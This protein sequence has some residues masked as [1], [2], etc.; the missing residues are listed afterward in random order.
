MDEEESPPQTYMSF[1][2]L[3]RTPKTWGVPYMAGLFILCVSLLPALVLGTFVHGLGW[4]FAL[5]GAPLLFY[6][7]S[8]CETDDRAL[9]V[10]Q[11]EIKWSILKKM[12]GNAKFYGGLMTVAPTSYGRKIF[13]VRR[14]MEALKR[15][16]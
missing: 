12:G 14:G 13:N 15:P 11:L 10:L 6:V 7:K 9:R 2:G 3:G 8:Q 4:A 16:C 5:I 1:N